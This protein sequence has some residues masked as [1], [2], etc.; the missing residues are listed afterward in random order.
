MYR[1]YAAACLCRTLA[2]VSSIVLTSKVRSEVKYMKEPDLPSE[3][4]HRP[5]LPSFVRLTQT[6]PSRMSEPR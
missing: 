2:S 1:T 5:P 3:K 6:W 4:D